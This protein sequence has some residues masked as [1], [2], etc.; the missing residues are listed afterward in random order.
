MR[1]THDHIDAGGSPAGGDVT[2][3]QLRATR[4]DIVEV[5]PGEHMNST[6]PGL[7]GEIPDFARRP[8]CVTDD[9]LR[10][11]R[12]VVELHDRTPL[13]PLATPGA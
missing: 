2:G 6:D 11:L 13:G 4:F 10:R 12:V 9:A 5:S 1:G 3:M 8:R 7:G